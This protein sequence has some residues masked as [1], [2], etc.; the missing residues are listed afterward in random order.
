[1]RRIPAGHGIYNLAVT[2][3][4]K[5]VATN[6]RDQSASIF[7][8][9][10]GSET[11]RIP[12]PRKAPHGVVVSPDQRYAFVSVEGMAAEPGTIVMIDLAS[13][14]RAASVDVAPQ[15]GGIDFWKAEPRR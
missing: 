8:P 4:G 2:T 5:L 12:L 1:M 13:G 10:A 15:A 7:D 14:Q 11:A 9:R 6:R 3:D